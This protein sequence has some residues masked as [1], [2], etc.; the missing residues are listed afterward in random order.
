M[1][2]RRLRGDR[3]GL[4]LIEL[5]L[6]LTILAL[7]G[8]L[9][10]GAFVTGLRA[11]QSGLRSGREELVA[12][13]VLERIA[14]QLRAAIS[15]PARHDEGDAVAFDAAEDHLRFVTLAAAGTAPVQVFY[16]LRGDGGD[17]H[18]VYREYPWPDKEFFGDGR[19]RREE[20]IPEITGFSVKVVKRRPTPSD[21]GEDDGVLSDGRV[22]PAG[23]E[24]AGERQ[25]GNRRRRGRSAGA[26]ALP[27]HRAD[28]DA[29]SPLMRCR[30]ARGGEP[31]AGIALLL[32]V[33][34][35]A[36][37]TVIAGEFMASGRV[38][39]AA[40][41]NK[42]DDLRGLALAL[43]GYRAAVA[44]LDDRIEGLEL[45]DGRNAAAA[46]SRPR[47]RCAGRRGSTCR[48]ATAPTRGASATRT[49]W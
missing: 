8:A 42:R 48:S 13:I 38:K 25:R 4:T 35:L 16:G 18:L 44:A 15:S 31:Q 49:V 20:K 40:E 5:V 3:R 14:T 9:V 29:G 12:R 23:R 27:D 10:S 43:A 39:A 17:A 33:W 37:L 45:D 6:T 46:L 32:V 28:P 1:I 22:E 34:L 2:R 30:R 21:T 41:H 36:L 19:P 26:A 24:A 7:A 11:W 47:G